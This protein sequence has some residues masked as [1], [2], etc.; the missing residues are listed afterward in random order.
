[1][2]IILLIIK[3]RWL[4]LDPAPNDQKIFH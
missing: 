1:M 2:V 3:F 4:W